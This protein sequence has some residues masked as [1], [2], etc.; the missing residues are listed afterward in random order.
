VIYLLLGL[1]VVYSGVCFQLARNYIRPARY[2]PVRPPWLHEVKV[3]TRYG[4]TPSWVTDGFVDG[5]PS[6]VVFVMAHGYGG[7]RE[8]WSEPMADLHARGF[9]CVALSMPGQDASPAQTV[10][11]G[12]AEGHTVADAVRWTRKVTDGKSKVVVFGVSMGGAACWLAT[13]EDPTIDGIVTEGAYARFDQAMNTFFNRK[14]PGGSVVLSPV[15]TFAKWMTGLEP[16][17]VRPVD[18]AS[19]WQG[20]PA[21]VIQGAS[22]TLIT[23]DQGHDLSK[24]AGCPEWVVPEAEHAQCFEVARAEYDSRLVQFANRLSNA[25]ANRGHRVGPG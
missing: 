11:F 17:S 13:E 14:M 4:P 12:I 10:G 7:S 21:L 24:A 23:L 5:K 2:V 3:D 8:T 16:K 18:S 6:Q 20:R 15:V 25:G 22:D 9:D 19:K 1:A